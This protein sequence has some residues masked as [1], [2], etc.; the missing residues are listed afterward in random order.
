MLSEVLSHAQYIVFPLVSAVMFVALFSATLAWVFRRGAR[1]EYVR[2][3]RA[4]LDDGTV[5]RD[6]HV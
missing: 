5:E 4:A 1:E 3:G 6:D 2:R